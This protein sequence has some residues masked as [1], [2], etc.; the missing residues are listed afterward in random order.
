VTQGEYEADGTKPLQK[1]HEGTNMTTIVMKYQHWIPMTGRLFGSQSLHVPV[2]LVAVCLWAMTG[3][4]V[5]AL[6]ATF[7]PSAD[8]A[9]ILAATE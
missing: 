2:D 9:G 4:M 5:T 3:L 8:L 1:V 6:I 7:E